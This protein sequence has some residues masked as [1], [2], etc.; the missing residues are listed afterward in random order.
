MKRKLARAGFITAT[1]ITAVLSFIMFAGLIYLIGILNLADEIVDPTIRAT[2]GPLAIIIMVFAVLFCIACLVLNSCCIPQTSSAQKM[3][4]KKGLVIT[5]L[6]FNFI[7]IAFMLLI[8][9][10]SLGD[11]A[12][13]VL[14]MLGLITSN[15]LILVDLAHLSKAV[16]A[17]LF[18]ENNVV[19]EEKIENKSVVKEETQN[20]IVDNEQ[21]SSQPKSEE[22]DDL[23]AELNKLMLMKEKKLITEEEFEQLKKRAIDKKLSK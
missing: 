4:K 2:I 19:V 15:V 7:L 23:E 22:M 6:V 3:N 20:N 12:M 8:T 14:C 13:Y 1:S 17:E 11:A 5:T 9:I 21:E 18:A 10:D 16:N